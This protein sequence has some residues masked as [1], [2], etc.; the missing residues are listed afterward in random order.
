MHIA[1]QINFIT[2]LPFHEICFSSPKLCSE[3]SKCKNIS[4]RRGEN[5][6][7][8]GIFT[9]SGRL[10]NY[11]LI[12]ASNQLIILRSSEIPI[13]ELVIS[14][15]F[16][17]TYTNRALKGMKADEIFTVSRVHAYKQLKHSFDM[18]EKINVYGLHKWEVKLI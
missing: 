14:I 17:S 3:F 4:I 1:V 15:G 5:K 12:S 11:I 9:G 7:I 18:V 13:G 8:H 6:L 10:S 16:N 2:N